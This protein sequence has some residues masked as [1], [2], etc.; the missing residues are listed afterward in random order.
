[1]LTVEEIHTLID[2]IA[3]HLRPAKIIIFGSYAK[4][5]ATARSDLDLLVVLDTPV[6]RQ[7]RSQ[8][9]NPLI[10]SYSVPIDVHVLTPAEYT[11]LSGVQ[12]S[13]IHAAAT[14]GKVAYDRSWDRR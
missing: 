13:F 8:L 14:T 5:T 6:S 11:A 4:Q 2:R 7:Y 3:T 9:I 12:H 1:M 10:A